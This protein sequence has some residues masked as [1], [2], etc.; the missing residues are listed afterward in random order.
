MAQRRGS[1]VLEVGVRGLALASGLDHSTVSVVLRA[2]REED[3]PVLEL[4]EQAK[5]EHADRYT[6]RIPEAGLH[7][8][9]WRR[10][11]PGRI[12]AIH[13]VFRELGPTAALVHETLT[14]VP[15]P[16]RDITRAAALPPR[17][18]DE[19]LQVLAEHGLARRD[20]HTGWRRGELTPDR[21][22][23]CLGV[24]LVQQE[25]VARYRSQRVAW[26]D[27]LD[28]LGRRIRI[29]GRRVPNSPGPITWPAALSA[30]PPADGVELA[31]DRTLAMAGPPDDALA[32][33]IALLRRELG[34]TALPTGHDRRGGPGGGQESF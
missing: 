19:A 2:L 13:P 20:P 1:R 16:R 15:S 17:T 34:A 25:L 29:P 23:P 3:D 24:D 12:V 8:A 26:R 6:L 18:V 11:K 9:S 33:A 5:G 30:P 14:E 32:A 27:L 7:A 4:L 10:W 31:Y 21:I 22:A 28:R